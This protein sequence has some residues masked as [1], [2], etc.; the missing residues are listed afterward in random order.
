MGSAVLRSNIR[1]ILAEDEQRAPAGRMEMIAHRIREIRRSRKMTHEDLAKAIGQSQSS[2]SMYENGSREPDLETLE[3]IAAALNVSLY[4]LMFGD[5]APAEDKSEN[6]MMEQMKHI[7]QLIMKQDGS[8]N[9]LKL[10]QA[11][12]LIIKM[13][14]ARNVMDQMGG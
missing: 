6:L 13:I 4:T 1:R 11:E 2:I 10:V 14:M 12:E 9:I 3:A 8:E 5:E 7:H